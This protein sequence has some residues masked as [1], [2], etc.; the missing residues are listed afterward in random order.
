MKNSI[1]VS[2]QTKL[3]L[4]ILGKMIKA[5]RLERKLSQTDLGDR[6]GVTRTTVAAI[7]KGK[8][9]VAIG[10]VFEAANVVGLPLMGETDDPKQ[11]THL[12]Q[13]VANILKILPAKG[14]GKKVELNDDF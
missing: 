9:N 6:I 10:T 3:R 11:L 14:T 1:V 7:E 12:S 5:A 8:S 2:V 4:E 13:S